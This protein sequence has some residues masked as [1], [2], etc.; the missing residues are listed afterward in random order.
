MFLYIGGESPID[1]STVMGGRILVNLIQNISERII[2][3]ANQK[4]NFL[5]IIQGN[6]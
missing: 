5:E 1:E 4:K 2:T 3:P 6:I